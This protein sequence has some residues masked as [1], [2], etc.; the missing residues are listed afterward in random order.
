MD[1]ILGDS[2]RLKLPFVID[3][4]KIFPI[5]EKELTAAADS[6]LREVICGL[7]SR[8]VLLWP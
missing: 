5:L 2:F 1:G 8:K 4:S 6:C 3:L 7:A